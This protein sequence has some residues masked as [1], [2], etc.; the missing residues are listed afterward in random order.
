M[1]PN[2]SIFGLK[3]KKKLKQIQFIFFGN[4]KI[5]LE[6]LFKIDQKPKVKSLR[7]LLPLIISPIIHL[8]MTHLNS[9]M[10]K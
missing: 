4:L 9:L 6:F 2:L 3:K 7:T 1:L 10:S 5:F 8:T